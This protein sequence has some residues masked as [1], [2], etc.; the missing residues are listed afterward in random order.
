[1]SNLSGF[2]DNKTYRS[3]LPP[4]DPYFYITANLD[5]TGLEVGQVEDLNYLYYFNKENNFNYLKDPSNYGGYYMLD[6]NMVIGEVTVYCNPEVQYEFGNLSN[7]R[8]EVGGAYKPSIALAPVLVNDDSVDVWSGP[9]GN[10]PGS[11]TNSELLN[12]QVC[13]YGREPEHP[14]PNVD[15]RPTE[16]RKYLVLNVRYQQP[17]TAPAS[18]PVSEPA[19]EDAQASKAFSRPDANA[20]RY[21]H[22]AR[23]KVAATQPHAKAQAHARMMANKRAV[24]PVVRQASRSLSGDV[25]LDGRI[26][27]VLKVYPKY[28][29]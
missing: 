6:D 21:V 24:A 5:L 14:H 27:V 10:V 16:S 11:I 7:L 12:A 28:V 1:M 26:F 4:A 18:A 22:V 25:L 15:N 9:T 17:I 2:G 23:P 20:S 29:H 19:P 8:F 3:T 13:Y